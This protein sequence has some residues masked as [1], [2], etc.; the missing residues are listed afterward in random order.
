MK[1]M[2]VCLSLII[3]NLALTAQ[4]DAEIDVESIV[5]LWL[6]DESSGKTA[7]DSSKK[8][9][10]GE[11]M[12]NPKSVAGKFGKALEFDG[13]DDYVA[14]PDNDTLDV[15]NVTLAAWVKS[16]AKQL[17]NGND[18]AYKK[19]S[20]IQQYWAQTINPGV[21][22]GGQ[23]CGSGWLPA[24]VIWDDDWHH[25]AV[26]YDGSTQKF[27]VDGVFK[28]ENTACSGKIDITTTEFTIGTGNTGFYTGSIDEVVI[29]D[30]PLDEDDFEIIITEGLE[31]IA[32]IFPADKLT[33]TW[34]NIKGTQTRYGK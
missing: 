24:A 28:G 14:V 22:V 8:G 9:N 10:D 34:G 7:K 11:I 5:G 13:K 18:I 4:S 19:T 1:T 17:V 21:F 20:Y 2:I 16:I 6:F 23:W 27:Y 15:T 25:V 32:A 31:D 33:T 29:F 3:I 12:N 30:V 26:T